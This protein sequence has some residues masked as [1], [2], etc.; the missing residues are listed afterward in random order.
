MNVGL[1]F[2][3]EERFH[4]HLTPDDAPRRW[5][6][7]DRIARILDLLEAAGK[8]ATFFVVGELAEHY[9]QLV[10]RMADAGFEVA[11]HSHSHPRLD[12]TPRDVC[13]A[14][15]ARS[16][17]LLEDLTGRPVLGFR[18]PSWSARLGDDWLWDHLVELGFRYDSS[19][20]PFP[21]HRYGSL[22]NPVTPFRLRPEL[23]EIPPSVSRIGPLRIPYGGGFWFRLYPQALTRRLIERDLRRNK[24][25]IVYFHP[26][27]FDRGETRMETDLLNSFIA[28]CNGAQAWDHFRAL[29]DLYPTSALADLLDGATGCAGTDAGRARS[30][31]AAEAASRP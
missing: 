24:A 26:W 21:T 16:K 14:D 23:L 29:V 30:S 2:D 17:A 9:P 18:A 8:R 1:T 10:R 28:N 31:A 13:R 5:D 12:A 4:S 15:I 22:R 3:V 25:P 20:F 7:G 6:A 11:S 27:E 19:L